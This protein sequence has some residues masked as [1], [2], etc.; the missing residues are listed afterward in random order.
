MHLMIILQGL[1]S[2]DEKIKIL[3]MLYYILITVA[4]FSACFVQYFIGLSQ[5]SMS[6]LSFLIF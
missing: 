5:S 4:L 3:M 6:I 1:I 2:Y